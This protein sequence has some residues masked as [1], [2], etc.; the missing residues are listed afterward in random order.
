LRA[1][2]EAAPPHYCG[3]AEAQKNRRLEFV[4]IVCFLE[5]ADVF[6]AGQRARQGPEKYSG[7]ADRVSLCEIAAILYRLHRTS[8]AHVF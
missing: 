8:S 4:S 6:K 3:R 5:V 7:G 2:A 1:Y